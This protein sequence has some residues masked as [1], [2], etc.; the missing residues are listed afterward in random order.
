M[1]R[2]SARKCGLS[3]AGGDA[4]GGPRPRLDEAFGGP[5]WR[6][7]GDVAGLLPAQVGDEV[8]HI[9]DVAVAATASDNVAVAGVRFSGKLELPSLDDSD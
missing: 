7:A 6:D 1:A 4:R 9:G 2:S 8:G 5:E 3:A